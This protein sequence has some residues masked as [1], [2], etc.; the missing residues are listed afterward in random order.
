VYKT[1]LRQTFTVNLKNGSA[2]KYS[3]ETG[4]T[5]E[6]TLNDE[7]TGQINVFYVCI[8]VQLCH[9]YKLGK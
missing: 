4:N 5:L 2:D 7:N 3:E 6:N 9:N 8:G 1:V